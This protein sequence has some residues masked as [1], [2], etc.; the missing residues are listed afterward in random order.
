[1]KE[2]DLSRELGLISAN[3]DAIKKNVDKITQK[4]ESIDNKIETTTIRI[5]K[6][7]DCIIAIQERC[8]RRIVT[9]K[10]F[11]AFAISF[12]GIIATYL[13]L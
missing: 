9:T 12:A 7:D 6:H 8:E 5:T 10:W 3:I 4:I 1:M 11:I 13:K 2:A